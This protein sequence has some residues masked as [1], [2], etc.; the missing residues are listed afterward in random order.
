MDTL[1]RR[2]LIIPPT[3]KG[4]STAV[5]IVHSLDQKPVVQYKRHTTIRVTITVTLAYKHIFAY[6]LSSDDQN[7]FSIYFLLM[8][9]IL[10]K[11]VYK[12]W[13]PESSENHFLY[14]ILIIIICS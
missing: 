10:L 11:S 14:I 8:Y 9:T 5:K 6:F 13:F 12:K 2:K 4:F 3:T 1:E 7:L